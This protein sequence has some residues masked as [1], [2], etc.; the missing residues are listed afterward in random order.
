[1]LAR[2]RAFRVLFGA[3]A[4]AYHKIEPIGIRRPLDTTCTL[5]ILERLAATG[6]WY[7]Q[8]LDVRQEFLLDDALEQADTFILLACS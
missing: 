4:Y 7:P 8:L 2:V 6:V 3:Y 1:M 5:G